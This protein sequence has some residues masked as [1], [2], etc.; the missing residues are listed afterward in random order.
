MERAARGSTLGL[1]SG[2]P[3]TLLFACQMRSQIILINPFRMSARSGLVTFRPSCVVCIALALT[4]T[5]YFGRVLTGRVP[6]TG[7][8]GQPGSEDMQEKPACP[9]RRRHT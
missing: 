6:A 7:K 5:L 9:D 8:A 1:L 4:A 3:V 2:A